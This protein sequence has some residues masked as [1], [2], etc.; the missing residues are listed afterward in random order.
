MK[1]KIFF[2]P[3]YWSR[4]EVRHCIDIMHVEKNVCDILIGTVLNINE[5]TKDSLNAR[6]DLIEMNIRGSWQR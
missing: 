2:D 6:L 3:P 5:K 4:L 1:I